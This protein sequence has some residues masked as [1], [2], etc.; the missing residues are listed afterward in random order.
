VRSVSET[1]KAHPAQ[2]ALCSVAILVGLVGCGRPAADPGA[3]KA[4]ADKAGQVALAYTRALFSGDLGKARSLVEPGSRSA[5]QVVA[6]GVDPKLV[7]A[8]DLSV[9]TTAVNGTLADATILGTICR[10]ASK[11]GPDQCMTNTDPNTTNPIFKVTLAQQP[12]GDWRVSFRTAVGPQPL[13]RRGSVPVPQA[14]A[15]AHHS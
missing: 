14:S 8:R 11:P 12:N 15:T 10:R 5:F 13:R 7:T 3:A 4:T 2:L 9:G 1:R 6:V